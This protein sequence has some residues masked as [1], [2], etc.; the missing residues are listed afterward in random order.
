LGCCA[1]L[2]VWLAIQ[3][4][5]LQTDF[6]ITI[7]IQT[8]RSPFEMWKFEPEMVAVLLSIVL[9]LVALLQSRRQFRI[10]QVSMRTFLKNAAV[11]AGIAL[12]L[13]FA[14]QDYEVSRGR[15]LEWQNYGQGQIQAALRHYSLSNPAMTPGEVRT[16]TFQQLEQTG[17]LTEDVAKWLR[18]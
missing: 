18:N 16:I 13:G 2:G 1:L 17:R 5:G 8:Q 15:V 4:G 6:W 11:L 12:F 7:W 3:Y 14:F 9:G 10:V